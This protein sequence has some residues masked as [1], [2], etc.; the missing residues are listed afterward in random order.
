MIVYFSESLSR[1]RLI[2]TSFNHGWAS[3]SLVLIQSEGIL[4][5][6]QEIKFLTSRLESGFKVNFAYQI[7]SYKS[8]ISEALNGT[9]PYIIA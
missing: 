9:A 6:I 5:S 3:I 2:S 4:S 8:S 7:L 1:S